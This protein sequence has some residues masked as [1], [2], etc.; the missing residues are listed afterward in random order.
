MWINVTTTTLSV[1]VCVCVCV[2]VPPATMEPALLGGLA[3]ALVGALG[4]SI[5]HSS[6]AR[7][8]AREA[9]A[10]GG[11][12]P[13]LQTVVVSGFLVPGD[14]GDPASYVPQYS[15][16]T[17]SAIAGRQA[18]VL[19]WRVDQQ[20]QTG[21]RRY[22]TTQTSPVREKSTRGRQEERQEHVKVSSGGHAETVVTE[23]AQTSYRS[24]L[25][26]TWSYPSLM[27]GDLAV[28]FAPGTT[29]LLGKT[30][31]LPTVPVASVHSA[32]S[33]LGLDSHGDLLH[34]SLPV[35]GYSA[36]EACLRRGDYVSTVVD[37]LPYAAAR[38][39]QNQRPSALPSP[40]VMRVMGTPEAVSNYLAQEI[41]RT[42]S[43]GWS[44]LL[45]ATAC[46]LL[47]AAAAYGISSAM[48]GRRST[49]EAAQ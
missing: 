18:L 41:E 15:L 33:L 45:S 9:V 32:V 14:N 3:G 22:T 47:G 2:S 31:V 36:S 21:V 37:A 38:Q 11:P 26:N 35:L 34:T 46:G 12:V 40:C 10:R 4:A 16:A 42:T 7:E 20:V 24:V 19:R 49:G 25:R 44:T 27:V 43:S 13:G 8:H 17:G 5:S 6:R 29:R 1:C 48:K 28:E 39:E 30:A 23:E